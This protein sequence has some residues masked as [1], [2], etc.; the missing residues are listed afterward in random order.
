MFSR[1]ASESAKYVV[2]LDADHLALERFYSSLRGSET[3]NIL[4]LVANLADPSPGLGWKGKERRNLLDRGRPDMVL[5][6]ALIHHIVIAANIPVIAFVEWLAS[7]G[8][9][10]VIEFVSKDDAMVRRLLSNK[11][12]QYDDYELGHFEDCLKKHFEVVSRKSLSSGTRT[13]Y[14][15]TPR[16]G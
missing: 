4:P 7:L 14:H 8:A 16:S 5:A 6:L 2:A 13:L 12:D 11:E 9:E 10:L 15:A 3:A 1:I